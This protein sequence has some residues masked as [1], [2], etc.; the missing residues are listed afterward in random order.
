MSLASLL[1][2]GQA[3]AAAPWPRHDLSPAVWRRLVAELEHDPASLAGLWA[4]TERVMALF[5]EGGQTWF[6]SCLVTASGYDALSPVRPE[7]AF[8][9][10]L[11]HDLWGHRAHGVELP[12]L[13]D[14]GQWPVI[15]PL[16]ARPVQRTAPPAPAVPAAPPAEGGFRVSLGPVQGRIA[17]AWRIEAAM[18]GERMVGIVPHLGHVH[19]GISLLARGKPPRAAARFAARIAADATIAHALAFARAAEAIAGEMPPPRALALREAM[20]AAERITAALGRLAGL[21]G[22]GRMDP[23]GIPALVEGWREAAAQGFGHR[24]MMDCVVPGG[25][26]ADLAPAGAAAFGAAL[27]RTAAALAPAGPLGLRRSGAD[28]DRAIGREHAE[29]AAA[30]AALRPLLADLPAGGVF[31]SPELATGEGIGMAAGPR[32]TIWHWMRL[33]H[34][35]I[36]AFFPIDPALAAWAR[37]TAACAGAALSDLGEI[38][39]AERLSAAGADL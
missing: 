2:G 23:A 5:T 30:V 10:R 21:A 8:W 18:Q 3:L 12:P 38:A 31:R 19:R 11:V 9:Q 28:R 39:A 27:A 26:A 25:L 34:G 4:D 33:D 22:A 24:L 36:A 13:L 17:P 29:I 20:A 37:F 1:R 35:L 14:H 7:A 16:A 32:G 6:V 15:A